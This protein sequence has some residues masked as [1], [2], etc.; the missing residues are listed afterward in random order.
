VRI[1]KR[2][3]C[4]LSPDR[5]IWLDLARRGCC[6]DKDPRPKQFVT[7]ALKILAERLAIRISAEGGGLFGDSDDT[8]RK[9]NTDDF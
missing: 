8:E 4:R 1:G 3:A 6:A 9:E 5:R 2:G 7:D